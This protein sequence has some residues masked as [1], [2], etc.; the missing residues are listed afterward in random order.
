VSYALLLTQ[1]PGKLEGASLVPPFPYQQ[2]GPEKHFGSS[3]FSYPL[4]CAEGRG[5]VPPL[6]VSLLGF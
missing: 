6:L 3:G 5:A 4:L 1:T 2:P